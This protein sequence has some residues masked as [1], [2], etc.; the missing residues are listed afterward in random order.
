[1]KEELG[2]YHGKYDEMKDLLNS[3]REQLRQFEELNDMR[4]EVI[5]RLEKENGEM[6]R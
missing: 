3:C 6:K 4:N 2:Y 5:T 1:M